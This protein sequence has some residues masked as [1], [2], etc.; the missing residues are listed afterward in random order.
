[1]STLNTSSQKHTEK[2]QTLLLLDFMHSFLQKNVK[3]PASTLDYYSDLACAGSLLGDKYFKKPFNSKDDLIKLVTSNEKVKNSYSQMRYCI[4]NVERR[5]SDNL[6]I[7]QVQGVL[8][9]ADQAQLGSRDFIRLLHFKHVKDDF[10]EITYDSISIIEVFK[11]A[12][13]PTK[14]NVDDVLAIEKEKLSKNIEN[15]E[16]DLTERK[17]KIAKLEEKLAAKKK[18]VEQK[19]RELQELQKETAVP[20]IKVSPENTSGKVSSKESEVVTSKKAQELIRDSSV[21]PVTKTP[22]L[23]DRT[24]EFSASPAQPNSSKLKQPS[25]LVDKTGSFKTQ[26]FTSNQ[27]SGKN[28]RS[29]TKDQSQKSNKANN[30]DGTQILSAVMTQT[31]ISDK[32]EDASKQAENDK[33]KKEHQSSE[34]QDEDDD[35]EWETVGKSNSAKDNNKSKKTHQRND[36]DS[37]GYKKKKNPSSEINKH[38]S[39]AN[40]KN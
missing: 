22:I 7:L 29:G 5:V 40:K 14:D 37:S 32:K 36:S 24:A 11:T 31:V 34:D 28:K 1:M 16:T 30:G 4:S 23:T 8:F 2:F 3:N 9:Q 17:E 6:I 21:T 10:F 26:T 15:I 27:S 38:K 35:D 33:R 13:L 12:S 18:D 25:V 39:G 19:K 20:E